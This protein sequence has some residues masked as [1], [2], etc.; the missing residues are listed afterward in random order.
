MNDSQRPL[1]KSKSW[2]SYKSWSHNLIEFKLKSK[3]MNQSDSD[4]EQGNTN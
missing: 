3:K 2:H 1:Q 4:R